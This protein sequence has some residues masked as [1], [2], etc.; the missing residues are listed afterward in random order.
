MAQDPFD[1]NQADAFDEPARQGGW[2]KNDQLQG[3]LLLVFAQTEDV[4]TGGKFGD[5]PRIK[6]RTVILDGEMAGKDIEGQSYIGAD[7]LID[8]LRVQMRKGRP[9]LGRLVLAPNKVTK[10]ALGITTPDELDKARAAWFQAG[11][12]GSE[13]KGYWMFESP[14]DADKELARKWMAQ[15]SAA[16]P[17]SA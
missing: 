15:D 2:L 10:Q 14:T 12:K 7:A 4:F 13:P 8:P 3:S 6:T 17:F 5:Q 9:L 11:G 16:D 1:K